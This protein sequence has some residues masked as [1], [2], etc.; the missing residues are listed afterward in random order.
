ML[1]ARAAAAIGA[2]G[3]LMLLLLVGIAWRT[4]SALWFLAFPLLLLGVLAAAAVAVL[5][6]LR[7]F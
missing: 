4:T 3:L 2:C 7:H 1:T 6:M 5:R